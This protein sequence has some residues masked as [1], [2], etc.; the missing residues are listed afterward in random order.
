MY[1]EQVIKDLT[2]EANGLKLHENGV[3]HQAVKKNGLLSAQRNNHSPSSYEDDELLLST[4]PFCFAINRQVS[5]PRY[6]ICQYFSVLHQPL[7]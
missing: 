7:V 1:P 5:R 2:A 6:H 3:K 4:S